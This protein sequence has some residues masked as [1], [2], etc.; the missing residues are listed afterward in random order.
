VT[1]VVDS[2][3]RE[4]ALDVTRSFCVSAPAGSGKTELLI[5]RYLALLS[6]VERPEQVLAIT[7]TRKA[8]A[9][10]RARVLQALATAD[11]EGEDAHRRR[12][13]RLARQVLAVDRQRDWQLVRDTGRMNIRTIDSFCAALT[14]QMPV[15]SRFGGP[16]SAVDDAEAYYAEA[17]LELFRQLDEDARIAP[18]LAALMRHFDNDLERLQRLLVDMLARRDQWQGYV[19][20]HHAPEESEAYLLGCVQGLVTRAI[21]TLRRMLA[22]WLGELLELQDR[23]AANRGETPPSQAPLSGPGALPTWRALRSGLLT[24]GGDWRRRLDRGCGFP[25]GPGAPAQHKQ[26]MQ[27]LIGELAMVDGLREALAALDRLPAAEPGSRSWQLVLHLSRLLPLLEAHLLLV[28]QR[29]GLVDHCQVALSALQALGEDDAPTDLALRLDYRIEHILVDEFQDTAALQYELLRRLTRGWGSHNAQDPDRPRTLLVVGDGMQSIYGFRNANVGLFL[30]AREE[31]F[32]GVPLE[33]LVLRSNFRSDPGIVAWVNGAF[34]R[35]FPARDDSARGEVSFS[36]AVAARSPGPG[37][38][39]E[40]HCFPGDRD[41]RAEVRFVCDAIEQALAAPGADSLALLGR[42]RGQLQPFIDE[43]RR[44]DIPHAAPDIGR[45]AH[46]PLAADL[47]TLCRALASHADRV[48]WLALLRSPLCGFS[49]ADLLA[50]AA[51]GEFPAYHSVW[52]ALGDPALGARLSED[53]SR[54]HSHL[55]GPLGRALQLRDRRGLRAWVEVPWLALGG[56]ATA[57]HPGELADAESYFQLLE[58]AEREGRGLDVQWLERQLKRRPADAG[59]PAARL[60]VMTLHR[61]KGLEFDRVF[62]V[63]L[64][65]RPRSDERP[66]LL[67]DELLDASGQRGFLLAAD[68]RS[69]PGDPTLYNYLRERQREKTLLENTRLFYV[70]ATRAAHRLVLTATLG[71]AADSGELLAPPRA[72]LIYP[73]WPGV[74]EQ[75][76]PHPPTA[77]TKVAA[78]PAGRLFYRQ[79]RVSLPATPV[80]AVAA[81]APGAPVRPVPDFRARIVDRVVRQALGELSQRPVLPQACGEAERERWT[82]ALRRQGLWGAALAPALE[83]VVAAVALALAPGSPGRWLLAPEHADTR[84]AWTLTCAGGNDGFETLVVDRCFSDRESGVRWV[85]AYQSGRPPPGQAVERFLAQV[86]QQH[87]ERFLACG[88]LLPLP[89]TGALRFALYFTELGLLQALD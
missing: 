68:D 41:P 2:A 26:R 63:Q 12:T 22:P 71:Q 83:A 62:L 55:L 47:H 89:E 11:G 73:L 38:A 31:G 59:D 79:A 46:S 3:Q 36:G 66:L 81:P 75:A 82:L 6:R 13:A 37:P 49:L 69:R 86:T 48:A 84:N 5:Q 67:W 32:N 14:R 27:A 51:L 24:A 39:V 8:A 53:G 10:M 74:R 30:R 9:E 35:A 85:V 20:V 28:F 17:A 64:A 58:Q 4:R 50:T 44:R 23:A 60:Q 65:R 7:F 70:G 88:R 40:L 42:S 78:S 52:C 21:D 54:R 16:A 80:P 87:R 33:H 25:P 45:L 15:L 19:G 1:A 43:L 56:P 34:A 77:A 76:I 57:A 61:S 72:S 18:D 29:H